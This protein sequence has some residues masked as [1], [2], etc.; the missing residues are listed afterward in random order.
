MYSVQFTLERTLPELWHGGQDKLEWNKRVA[1]LQDITSELLA[2]LQ[3]LL[4]LL[5]QGETLHLLQTSTLQQPGGQ[6]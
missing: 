4:L 2:L 3:L 5:L 6:I 1:G